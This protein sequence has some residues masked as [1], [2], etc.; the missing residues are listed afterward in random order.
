MKAYLTSRNA[1]AAAAVTTAIAAGAV[2]LSALATT[3]NAAPIIVGS[4]YEDGVLSGGTCQS[5]PICDVTF[6]AIPAGRQVLITR[7]TCHVETGTQVL[8]LAKLGLK[9]GTG[10]IVF[11]REEILPR[12]PVST[13]GP[14]NNY[15]QVG[16]AASFLYKQNQFPYVRVH[17]P[18]SGSMFLQCRITGQL[19]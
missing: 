5:F 6:S 14:G 11:S 19:L 2:G 1:V 18:V 17:Q 7:V 4:Y 13:S 8:T 12:S 15:Y 3:A 10:A 9:N 16:G